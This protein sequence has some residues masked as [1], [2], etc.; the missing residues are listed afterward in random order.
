VGLLF[1]ARMDDGPGQ[2]RGYWPGGGWRTGEV[3][4]QGLGMAGSGKTQA[5]EKNHETQ[6]HHPWSA[7]EGR[8]AATDVRGLCLIRTGN[9]E[10]SFRFRA[11]PG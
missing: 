3:R 2:A 9:R 5:D 10:K 4:P 7:G 6:T 11:G 1:W 8:Q